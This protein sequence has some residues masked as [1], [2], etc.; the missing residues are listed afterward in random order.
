MFDLGKAESGEQIKAFPPLFNV[1]T[2]NEDRRDVHFVVFPNE[3]PAATVVGEL[4]LP[5]NATIGGGVSSSTFR[6]LLKDSATGKIIQEQ[7]VPGT[8]FFFTLPA[9]KKHYAIEIGRSEAKKLKIEPISEEFFADSLFTFVRLIPRPQQRSVDVEVHKANY[10]GL[11]LILLITLAF[12]NQTKTKILVE[13]LM[14]RARKFIRPK[15]NRQSVQQQI[16]LSAELE[17]RRKAKKQ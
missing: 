3:L 16:G 6:V 14:E 12:L 9:Y 15:N 10:L 4:E 1:Q 17:R 5:A 13:F 2:G 8:V 7:N 11:A